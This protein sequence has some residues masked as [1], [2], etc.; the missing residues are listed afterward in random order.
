MDTLNDAYRLDVLVSRKTK[1]TREQAKEL[2][3]NGFVSV[4]SMKAYKPGQKYTQ[5]VNIEIDTLQNKF[6]SRGGYKLL[7]AIN[8]FNID[9]RNKVCIDIGSSTGGFTDCL[10]QNGANLVYAIDSGKDQLVQSLKLHN[11][12][13]SMEQ[14]NIRNITK[15]NI[16]ILA[17][18][19][20]IDVSFISLTKVLGTA[21]SL[22]NESGEC[23]CLVKPQF[24]AGY[25][26]VT[27]S[28][29]VK[30]TKIHLKVLQ[31]IHDHVVNLGFSVKGL[32]NS[33]IEGKKGNKEYLLYI[34]KSSKTKTVDRNI[35]NKMAINI[36]K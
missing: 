3:Q 36:I 13:I 30:N 14:T 34:S 24:E 17:D 31:N 33:P 2:I 4:N 23:I 27:K 1:L 18:I 15:E 35:F 28:G 26:N 16:N 22:L 19:I 6:V 32:T 9:I 8:F 20:V 21:F 10:L 25:K 11:K 7:K 29:I 5:K 12:V